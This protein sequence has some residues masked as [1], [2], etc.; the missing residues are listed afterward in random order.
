MPVKK[1]NSYYSKQRVKDIRSIKKLRKEFELHEHIE[2][3]RECLKCGKKFNSKW[4]GNR[5]CT[6]CGKTV[7]SNSSGGLEEYF[8]GKIR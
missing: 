4:K 7:N 6:I 3:K 5:L 1:T 8:L 2:V